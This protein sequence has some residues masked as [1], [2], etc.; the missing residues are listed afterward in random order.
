MGSLKQHIDDMLNSFD[1]T[2][3]IENIKEYYAKT[4]YVELKGNQLN[5]VKNYIFENYKEIQ[6]NEKHKCFEENSSI[7]D[8][9]YVNDYRYFS[10]IEDV[11]KELF[12]FSKVQRQKGYFKVSTDPEI[13]AW[14]PQF[15]N[16][17]WENLFLDDGKTWT[18]K[19]L[20]QKNISIFN[21]NLVNEFRYIFAHEKEGYRFTGLFQEVEIKDKNTRIYSLVDDKMLIKK[22]DNEDSNYVTTKEVEDYVKQLISNAKSN[23]DSS[24][25]ISFHVVKSH[26][27]ERVRHRA[28]TV[29]NAIRK[30]MTS[31]DKIIYQ[32]PKGN[33]SLF[34]VEF[35]LSDK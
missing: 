15:G 23:G 35:N 29:C 13:Y 20:T 4:F 33:S 27:G 11:M 32:S 14:F 1:G 8:Y 25:V 3:S 9:L 5:L 21:Q 34:E 6:F 19:P 7:D 2:I 18:E 17:E 24:I 31:L 12:G 30:N 26:F 16:K 10:S 28:P 22:S